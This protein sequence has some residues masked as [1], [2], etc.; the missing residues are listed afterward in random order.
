MYLSKNK[1]YIKY[2]FAFIDIDIK[3][4]NVHNTINKSDFN[5]KIS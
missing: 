5:V 2:I 3:H 1:Y 4:E